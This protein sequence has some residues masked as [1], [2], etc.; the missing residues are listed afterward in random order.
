M[1]IQSNKVC[2]TTPL[3]PVGKRQAGGRGIAHRFASIFCAGSTAAG[4]QP[5]ITSFLEGCRQLWI[6]LPGDGLAPARVLSRVGAAKAS[7]HPFS[8]CCA[9]RLYAAILD[10]P[11][12]LPATHFLVLK[13][14]G[15]K[16]EG[17]LC[18]PKHWSSAPPETAAR[19]GKM[20]LLR[21]RQHGDTAT[22]R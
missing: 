6:A 18:C 19:S 7:R 11:S 14:L 8:G 12:F 22:R 4:V 3:I 9:T 1:E 20:Q 17:D 2:G 5:Q 21:C 15:L 16:G 10:A 13:Y